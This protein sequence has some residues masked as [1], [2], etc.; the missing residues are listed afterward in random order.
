MLE[1][2][3]IT[4]IV[5]QKTDNYD[6][7]IGGAFS[8]RQYTDPRP[9]F[10][11]VHNERKEHLPLEKHGVIYVAN[12]IANRFQYKCRS[13]IVWHP[14]CRL[15]PKKPTGKMRKVIGVVNINRDKGGYDVKEVAAKMPDYHFKVLLSWGNQIAIDLPNVELLPYTDDMAAF[16]ASIDTLFC[17]SYSEGYNTTVLEAMSQGC[18]IVGRSIPGIMEVAGD[19]GRYN[20]WNERFVLLLKETTFEHRKAAFKR[21]SEVQQDES[22][23]ISYLSTWVKPTSQI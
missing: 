4:C 18:A 5:N 2:H 7:V 1:R 6:A 12:H 21:F 23:F 9:S 11:I 14:M 17:P 19:A 13:S 10:V 20:D 8:L 16:Y 15:T 22:D 3:G